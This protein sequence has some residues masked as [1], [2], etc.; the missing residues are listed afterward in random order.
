MFHVS[1][2][3]ASDGVGGGRLT[4]GQSAAAEQAAAAVRGRWAF[5]GRMPDCRVGVVLGSGLQE[6]AEQAL[7]RGACAVDYRD[8]PGM[9]VP[10]VPDHAGRLIAGTT[11]GPDCIWMQGRCHG[12][13]GRS[14][15]E[16]TFSI[17]LL[18][19]L[20]VR[21]LILTNAA[22]A[23]AE[24]MQ[25]GSFMLI[26][27]HITLVDLSPLNVETERC[28]FGGTGPVWNE[29]LL[30]AAASIRTPLPIQRG[31]YAMM[32]GPNYETPA[33]VRMLERLGADAVG[34]STV[35]EA[36][37]GHRLGMDVVGISCLTNAAAG[38]CAGPVRHTDVTQ[39]AAA[40]SG[41][42]TAWLQN[43]VT[44]LVNDSAAKPRSSE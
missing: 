38:R 17:R 35:P 37:L 24:S 23:I 14:L 42:F 29:R 20:G 11:S 21:Q 36:V 25:P 26:D 7:A 15:Q 39:T 44:L 3:T 34:M 13:E 5:H 30:V 2:R 33:E 12:Y 41:P 6:A 22:G 43:L 4:A 8:I 27:D 28:R 16:V 10:G 18:H 31:C 19:A 9:P 1:L 40:V 32:S